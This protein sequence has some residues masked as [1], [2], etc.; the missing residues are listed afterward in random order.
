MNTE[1]LF[2]YTCFL[3]LLPADVIFETIEWQVNKVFLVMA[4][5]AIEAKTQY[6]DFSTSETERLILLKFINT[7]KHGF[8]WFEVKID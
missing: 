3:R 5:Q 7:D 4:S 6:F 1:L 2:E 8:N